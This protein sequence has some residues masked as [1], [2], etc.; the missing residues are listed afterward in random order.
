MITAVLVALLAASPTPPPAPSI[1]D[2]L[3]EL[4]SI[5]SAATR[6]LEGEKR[7]K[8]EAVARE[9]PGD[10]MPRVYAA[11]C[12]LPSDDAWNQ[13]KS[14]TAI[15]PDNA[16]AHLGMGRIYT[17]WKMKEQASAEFDLIL[18]RDPKFYPA[19]SARGELALAQGDLEQAEK[20]I[21]T[22][23]SMGED[24]RARGKLGLT[25]L[26]AGKTDAA[27]AELKQAAA[28]WPDQPLVLD[29][30]LKI[31]L[32]KKD[33]A[34]AALTAGRLVEIS[35][36]NQQA[37]R[38]LADLRYDEGKKAE[39]AKD[40]E[41]ILRQSDSD[42][43]LVQK[44]GGI[45]AELKDPA[46][47][48]RMLRQQ[49]A[50]DRTSTA[51][52][53]RL[54]ELQKDKAT[55]EQLE[56]LYGEVIERDPKH[57]LARLEFGRLL[58]KRKQLFLAA[59][60]FRVAA[61]STGPGVEEA[62]AEGAA[63]EATFKLPAKKAKGSVD[64]VNTAAATS[65]N[66]LYLERKRSQK[67]SG[68]VLKVKVKIEKDGTVTEVSIPEDTVGDPVLAAHLYFVMRDAAFEARKREPV[69]EFE[70]KGKKK[71]K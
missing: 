47:E 33:M 29:A 3:Q 60:S 61:L 11:W 8:W 32:E 68:G 15:H 50:I 44:L 35:P 55:G 53:M 51:P 10:P 25:L 16:W 23:L 62:K 40:Y 45:Y 31:E 19:I 17:T 65:L 58:Q 36:R 63:L 49:L 9:R 41:V 1:P 37:R 21:R 14:V 27:V 70:L 12:A 2:V 20:L 66:A 38:L 5:D 34:G 22:S 43:A 64:S 54:V 71:S 59:E 52:L 46:G 57:A 6:N 56:K 24:P 26:Q 67:L 69:F 13:L 4:R 48:E 18:S 28:A 39:A 30:L 42:L 7:I